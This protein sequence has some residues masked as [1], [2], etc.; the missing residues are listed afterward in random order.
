MK[1]RKQKQWV[2]KVHL[3]TGEKQDKEKRKNGTKWYFVRALCK[4][5]SF[6]KG[7]IWNRFNLR[8]NLATI[9]ASIPLNQG[10]VSKFLPRY[11][12]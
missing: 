9:S 10:N 8:E 2:L 4:K 3:D 11:L 12:P 6:S 1:K 5:L 7:R